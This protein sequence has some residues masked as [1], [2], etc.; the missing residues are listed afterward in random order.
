MGD[1]AAR[2]GGGNGGNG[3]DG[4]G[5][6]D[7]VYVVGFLLKRENA[8]RKEEDEPG[9]TA[10]RSSCPSVSQGVFVA[11]ILLA[12]DILHQLDPLPPS[13]FALSPSLILP[14]LPVRK[15]K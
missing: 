14:V 10:A 9:R 11:V 3:G 15:G 6:P 8:E 7:L 13:P 1:E 4:G 2:G 12:T 5:A